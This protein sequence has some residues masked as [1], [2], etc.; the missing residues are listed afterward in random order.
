MIFFK[1]H[2]SHFASSAHSQYLDP[3]DVSDF[4]KKARVP[5]KTA[6]S[7]FPS[8][9]KLDLIQT[10][11]GRSVSCPS[12]SG[13]SPALAIKEGRTKE[14]AENGEEEKSGIG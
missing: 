14:E 2:L 8:L 5:G 6:A 4:E 12:P 1:I 11:L 9:M 3:H 7:V 13:P 10:T